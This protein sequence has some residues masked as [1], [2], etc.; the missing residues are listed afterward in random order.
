MT[1]ATITTPEVEPTTCSLYPHSENLCSVPLGCP[2]CGW[3]GGRPKTG[4]PLERA[5]TVHDLGCE[6]CG[7]VSSHY[8]FLGHAVEEALRSGTVKVCGPMANLPKVS[9]AVE[10]ASRGNGEPTIT[11]DRTDHGITVT[12]TR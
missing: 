2:F 10:V 6:P 9:W 7:A 3:S 4:G 8:A 11:Y 12:V 1:S 5:T